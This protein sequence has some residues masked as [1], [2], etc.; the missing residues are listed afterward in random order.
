[1]TAESSGDTPHASILSTP[2]PG[3][4]RRALRSLLEHW[5]TLLPGLGAF[6]LLLHFGRIGYAPSLSFGDLGTVLGALLLFSLGGMLAFIMILVLPSVLIGY[7]IESNLLPPPPKPVASDPAVKRTSLRSYHRRSHVAHPPR[8]RRTV[9]FGWQPR[10]GSLSWF[11]LAAAWTLL[12]YVGLLLAGV[13]FG[14]PGIAQAAIIGVFA[15]ASAIVFG[16]TIAIDIPYVRRRLRTLR[17]AP[18][19][20]LLLSMLYFAFWPIALLPFFF[21]DGEFRVGHKM[22]AAMALLFVPYVHW[23]LYATYRVVSMQGLWVR[24]GMICLLLFYSSAPLVILDGALNAFGL[25]MMRRVDLVLSPRGC[26][27]VHAAWPTRACTPDSRGGGAAQRLENVEVLTRIGSHFYVAVPGGI[28]D[29]ALPRVMI[30]ATEV[31]SWHR[32]PE[33]DASAPVSPMPAS[34]A[35]RGGTGP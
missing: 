29:D 32:T 20:F 3:P 11:M 28:K 34:S 16:T 2:S 8:E 6:A 10:A 17:R 31:L 24:A 27:I 7:W 25:G 9:V 21:V 23:T 33:P 4:G 5:K 26:D 1:M 12:A 35:P 30:P 22:M 18:W 13:A 15:A 14:P 19:S